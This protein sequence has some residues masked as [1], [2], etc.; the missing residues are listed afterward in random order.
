MGALSQD[1]DEAFDAL[2][3]PFEAHLLSQV[4]MDSDRRE[5]RL[6]LVFDVLAI[7]RHRGSGWCGPWRSLGVTLV[8]CGHR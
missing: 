5:T 1:P 4:L 8:L 7:R 2:A 6:E 3:A